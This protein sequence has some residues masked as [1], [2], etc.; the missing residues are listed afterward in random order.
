MAELKE[1]IGMIKFLGLDYVDGFSSEC[2]DDPYALLNELREE[3]TEGIIESIKLSLKTES[4]NY[5]SEVLAIKVHRLGFLLRIDNK[6]L[7]TLDQFKKQW[8]D[9]IYVLVYFNKNRFD[10]KLLYKAISIGENM[11][12]VSTQ[13]SEFISIFFMRATLI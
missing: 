10:P 13:D 4:H 9:L 5:V 7:M 3:V 6:I 2:T 11:I 8:R 12:H 1:K